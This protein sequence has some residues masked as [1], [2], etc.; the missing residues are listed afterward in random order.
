MLYDM[1]ERLKFDD[2]PVLKI[3]DTE[4]TIKSDAPTVLKLMDIMQQNGEME[5]AV[6]AVDLL[7]SPKDRK[8]LDAMNLKMSDFIEVISVAVALAVGE[9]PDEEESQGEA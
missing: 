8:K 3:K 5:A 2:D 1:T 9:D 6:K 4:L 7:F